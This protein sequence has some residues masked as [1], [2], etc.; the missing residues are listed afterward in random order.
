MKKSDHHP[1]P[2]GLEMIS[3]SLIVGWI[4]HLH[5]PPFIWFFQAYYW[6]AIQVSRLLV[7][8]IEGVKSIY[9]SGSL[10][11]GEAIYGLSD[12][13]LKIFVAGEKDQCTYQNIRRC[14]SLLRRFFPIL[15]PP[16][17]KGICFLD[18]FEED[19][20]HYPL[21]QHFFDPLFFKH[22]LIWGEDL[23]ATLPLKSWDE[24]DQVECTFGR[25]K[26]W[27]EKVY[28]LADSTRLCPK[29]KQHLFF[30]AVADVCLLALRVVDPEF[31]FSRRAEI[32]R[33]VSPEMEEPYRKLMD[34]LI[35][36]NQSFY[37]VQINS[38][39]ESFQLFK[40]TVAFCAEK[41]A[42][43]DHSGASSISFT[44][45]DTTCG[46][47]HQAQAAV[48]REFS[49]KIRNVNVLLWPQLPLNPFDFHFFNI[50]VFIL[51]CSQPL[52][53]EEFHNLKVYYRANLRNR[54]V[55]L[56]REY[57]HF[58]SSV[59]SDLIEHRG[60]FRGASDLL[61]LCLEQSGLNP[62]TQLA[63]NRIWVR[64][65]AFL[66]QVSATMSHQEFGRMD[67]SIFPQFIFNA[68]R[69]VI[70][71][72]EFREGRWLLPL[73]S[74]QVLEYLTE[75]TPLSSSFSARL[76]EQFERVTQGKGRFDE[77]LMPK[78]RALLSEMLDVYRHANTWDDLK[79]LNEAANEHRM[80][81][82]VAI[83]TA[84]RPIQLERC[85]RSLVQLNRLPEELIVVDNGQEVPVRHII[86]KIQVPF[87]IRYLT[88]DKTGVAPARNLALRAASGEI[89]A[90]VDDDATVSRDW[91]ECLERVFVADPNVGLVGGSVLNMDCGRDNLVWKF[92]AVV[93][94]MQSDD[95]PHIEGLLCS[96]LSAEAQTDGDSPL[97][98]QC[99]SGPE[100]GDG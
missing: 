29:Q 43:R 39:D 8:R 74:S 70:F 97:F 5:Y 89:I 30:K 22:R 57:P 85:L 55:V 51:N 42:Y 48:L 23:I 44:P 16:D 4:V 100:A 76:L 45:P 64:T 31:R 83:I 60:S 82:S 86:E 38:L 47:E 99:K 32:L 84:N 94:R 88:F 54:T 28:I 63:R 69:M 78:S 7:G 81:I 52:S 77:R 66:E 15:G 6:L 53:L 73:T 96:G 26:W 3:R 2:V 24:L 20:R 91:L 9:L 87:P 35:R 14:F 41:A 56:L 27:L 12:I 67:H 59:D 40:K 62:L 10:A 11:R 92:M 65:S 49:P 18:S 58:V 80:R 19:Y 68:L 72:V 98:P 21:I 90:F 36:E 34:N 13:D 61:H 37:R 95:D 17:E 33:A 50:P 46:V 25:L 75:H 1:G 79:K 71:S 93:Q